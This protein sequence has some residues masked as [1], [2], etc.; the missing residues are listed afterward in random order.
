MIR[1]KLVKTGTEETAQSISE[2][3]EGH[4]HSTKVIVS[5]ILPWA[6]FDC[7]VCAD[8]YFASVG[9]AETLKKIG[10]RFIGVVK[11]ATKR[12]PMKNL[13][14]LELENRGGRRGLIM[15]NNDSQPA[16]LAFCWMDRDRRYFIVSGS[17]LSPG[18]PHIRQ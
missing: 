15:Y 2:D 10:L 14:E 17:S 9:A 18:M 8:S 11:T 7:V 13:S 1:L 3:E 5:L 12:F 4:L 16:L 6:N